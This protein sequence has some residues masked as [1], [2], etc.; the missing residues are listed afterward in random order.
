MNHLAMNTISAATVDGLWSWIATTFSLYSSTPKTVAVQAYR[1]VMEKL[2]EETQRALLEASVSAANLERL[3]EDLF[4]IHEICVREG[5]SLSGA[6][7]KLLSELWTLLGGNRDELRKSKRR[8][9]LLADVDQYRKQ[10]LDHV[11]KTR[12]VLKKVVAASL[13]VKLDQH[14]Y[15]N[16]LRISLTGYTNVPPLSQ[17]ILKSKLIPH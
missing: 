11:V 9:A 14:G 1:D 6:H 3:H 13:S 15:I 10:A 8:L 7:A 5:L 17:S 4:T 12:G 16:V 2:A